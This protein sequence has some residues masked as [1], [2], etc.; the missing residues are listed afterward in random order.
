MSKIQYL[1]YNGLQRYHELINN[2]ISAEGVRHY[3]KDE[4][5]NKTEVNGLVDTPHQNYVTV[6]ATDQTTAATDVLPASD[7]AADTIYRVSNWDG[8]ANSF[9][10][11]FDVTVYSEYAW[12][13]VSNPNKYIFLCVKS[14]IG[15]VFDIS[16][17]NNN[18]TYP[19]LASALGTN[20]ANIP[21]PL[22]KGGMSVKFV[23]SSDHKYMQYR[24]MKNQWSTTVSD[25]Q[26]V[27]ETPTY[28]SS[29][30]PTSKGIAELI[31]EEVTIGKKQ[32]SLTG[33]YGYT[34]KNGYLFDSNGTISQKTGSSA[35]KYRTMLVNNAVNKGAVLKFTGTSNRSARFAVGISSVPITDENITSVQCTVLMNQVF[36]GDMS[37]KLIVPF[38][39]YIA[40]YRFTDYWSNITPRV[41]NPSVLQD[42]SVLDVSELNNT[43][44]NSLSEAI[45]TIPETLQKGGMEIRFRQLTPATYT[46]VKTEGIS[47]QPAGTL[48]ENAPTIGSG[49]YKAEQLSDFATLPTTGTETY[50]VAVT[51]TVDEQEVTT[52]TTWVITKATSDVQKYVHYRLMSPTWSTVAA[53][54]QGVDDEIVF[55]SKNLPT[56]D[57]VENEF[58]VG[59]NLEPIDLSRYTPTQCYINT[60]V[61]PN[62]WETQITGRTG[63]FVRIKASRWY[64]ITGNS[65]Y[66]S[67]YTFLTSSEC[68]QDGQVKYATGCSRVMLS[69]G[70]TIRDY[71]P[72]DATYMYIQI[73]YD[74]T[75]RTPTSVFADYRRD[76]RKICMGTDKNI[77]P[78]LT[79]D[80]IRNSNGEF[81]T[82]TD[83]ASGSG[84]FTPRFIRLADNIKTFKVATSI[85]GILYV[86]SYGSNFEYLGYQT[87]SI[88]TAN[89][90]VSV[91]LNYGATYIKVGQYT[92]NFAI[93][94]IK[95][96]GVFADNW[97]TF[98]PRPVNVPSGATNSTVFAPGFRRI[99]VLVN[100]TNPTCCDSIKYVVSY[101][102]GGTTVEAEGI[103]SDVSELPSEGS[104]G[105]IYHIESGAN[106]GFYMY[107]NNSWTI[108]TIQHMLAND[109][110]QLLPDYGMIALPETYTNTGEPTRL[111][112]YCHGAAVNYADS[113]TG[114]NA[115][116]LNPSYW[117][118]EGYAVMDIEGNPFDNTNEH[119]SMPQATDSYVAG[120]KWAIEHFN[121]KRDGVFLGGRS[122][123]GGQTVTLMRKE[124]PIPIIAAC[125]NVPAL[126]MPTSST[127][128]RKTFWANHCG[129]TLPEG[130]VFGDGYVESE[131]PVF[132][133]N[134]DKWVKV[135]PLFSMI[136][137]LPLSV[138]GKQ[139][140]IDKL[141]LGGNDERDDYFKTFHGYAKC[142]VKFFAINQDEVC[143]RH[144][145]IAY[146]IL[147]NSCQRTE[148]RKMN[149]YKDYTGTGT[150][151]HH[152]DTQDP[153]LRTTV[154]TRFGVEM[155]NVPIV[156]IEMLE[157]WRRYEQGN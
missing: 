38:D 45:A 29:N 154:T 28:N 146:R 88:D 8:S 151:A 19:D 103:L 143:L 155:T 156:Y 68:Y 81:S 17:Y 145:Q 113:V 77:S 20:G 141:W 74:N 121:L 3:L 101:D 66:Y 153:A 67:Y 107:I 64:T 142:P 110:Q 108:V 40:Y 98:N 144:A 124:C 26:G 18:A 87:V 48:L 49:T 80:I 78:L 135:L 86:F 137:D 129:F 25:W 91:T 115:Q 56:S 123:G 140:V 138:N 27:D 71:A 76:I 93:P 13:D 62:V 127:A 112:I 23:C 100:V 50:Y 33:F 10:G 72:A 139:D 90:D 114:F 118:A 5:Y 132:L 69:P 14:Q 97:D 43:N 104:S 130:F 70:K 152:A 11:A 41:F 4:T 136:T 111:I 51:E 7:Q 16:V 106:A 128:V 55:G 37:V 1:D 35:S 53:N 73:T 122:M 63:I 83:F 126:A 99:S 12:D 96:T 6:Q 125:P 31:A 47:D 15:E 147:L 105:I 36:D 148:L 32:L 65:D 79:H 116:D 2:R 149:S 120:Y 95:L 58:L 34:I 82:N 44:Y 9:A 61:T 30:I 46:V 109:T 57:A 131:K 157:F 22:R 84:K 133:D 117:L 94:V 75:D 59:G 54:W 134:W 85:S 21:E 42:N 150:S 39:G 92:D 24:L 52:Y 119:C 102:D 89:T 60:T